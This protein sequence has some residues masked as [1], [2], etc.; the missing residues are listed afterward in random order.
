MSK[1]IV[2]QWLCS[3]SVSLLLSSSAS[4]YTL[5]MRDGRRI[6]IPNAFEV[7]AQVL[8][9]EAAP[10]IQITLQLAGIDVRAT[11]HLNNESAG[12]LLRR[13]ERMRVVTVIT[14]PRGNAKSITN[15]DLERFRKTREQSERAY[16]AR[17][18]ELGL[19]PL[20]ESRARDLVSAVESS[21]ASE[22]ENESYWRT[23]ASALRTEIVATDARISFLR[24]RLSELPPAFVTGAIATVFP[25][26]GIRSIASAFDQNQRVPRPLLYSMPGPAPPI[27]ARPTAGG[28]FHRGRPTVNHFPFINR[29][30]VRP[31]PFVP[32][33]GLVVPF[34]VYDYM[35]ERETLVLQLDQLLSYRAGLGAQWRDL[36]DEARRAGA[37]PGWLRP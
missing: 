13:S 6:V 37:Y 36:E 35:S 1:K 4:A 15:L 11:E 34:Q 7:S 10:G 23:R 19:P 3:L 25:V 26:V 24:G 18:K 30:N 20:A 14:A 27:Q 21:R 31:F 29:G 33:T 28:S 32:S 2:V 5:V 8:T 9:Y 17:R 12:S 16:E 22:Q